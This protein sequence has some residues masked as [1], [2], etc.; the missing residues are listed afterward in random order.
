MANVKISEIDGGLVSPTGDYLLEL[1]AANGTSYYSTVEKT[2][3][4][5]LPMGTYIDS[6][7]LSDTAYPFACAIDGNHTVVS[8]KISIYLSGAAHSGSDIYTIAVVN[9]LHGTGSASDVTIGTAT[10][11][12]AGSA[13]ATLINIPITQ[14]SLVNGF[15]YIRATK[16]GSASNVLVHAPMIK[17][18]RA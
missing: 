1:E 2:N 18:Q 8:M 16:G 11:D 14:A 3:F 7:L 12:G 4:Y 10:T 13:Q 5:F 9:R 6:G 15:V 17:V